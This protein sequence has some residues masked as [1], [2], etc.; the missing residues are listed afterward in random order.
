MPAGCFDSFMWM[1]RV[2]P[3]CPYCRMISFLCCVIRLTGPS[4]VQSK[5]TL[6]VSQRS[7][8]LSFTPKKSKPATNFAPAS[9]SSVPPN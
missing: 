3:N 5:M 8:G 4:N 1:V 2:K 9:V 7:R 6:V